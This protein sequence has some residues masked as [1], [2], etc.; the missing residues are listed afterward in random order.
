MLSS[1]P[2]KL[3]DATLQHEVIKKSKISMNSPEQRNWE[4][5]YFVLDRLKVL[6]CPLNDADDEV[7]SMAVMLQKYSLENGVNL[8]PA[9]A[10]AADTLRLS[11]FIIVYVSVLPNFHLVI[12]RRCHT[13]DYLNRQ[14]RHLCLDEKK[15]KRKW[16]TFCMWVKN[17]NK[18]FFW[19]WNSRRTEKRNRWDHKFKKDK[20]RKI[21]LFSSISEID[22]I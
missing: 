13:I 8:V 2:H 14:Y 10:A 20:K 4:S 15:W 17:N 21:N 6:L 1:M 5:S 9:N 19:D 12:V 16:K 3:S 22:K 7:D 11:F 18:N